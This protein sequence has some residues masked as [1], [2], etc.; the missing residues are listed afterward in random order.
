MFRYD[1]GRCTCYSLLQHQAP[2]SF[3][4]TSH[5]WLWSSTSF[6]TNARAWHQHWSYLQRDFRRMDGY[7]IA[8]SSFHRYLIL[9]YIQHFSLRQRLLILLSFIGTSTKAFFKGVETWK[10]ETIIKKVLW[11]F[12]LFQSRISFFWRW[13]LHLIL[14]LSSFCIQEAAK[15]FG[16]DSE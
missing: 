8:H 9:P 7:C 12:Y 13:I 15:R 16:F 1:H 3:P 2:S 11:N 4:R 5:H 6:P 14:L 10:K